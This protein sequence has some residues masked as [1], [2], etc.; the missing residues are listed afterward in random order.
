[1][2][3]ELIRRLIAAGGVVFRTIRAY[4]ARIIQNGSARFR[5]ATSLTRQASKLTP[6]LLKKVTDVGK[7]PTKREDYIETQQLF[8]AK[9]LIILLVVGIV[10]GAMLIYFVIWPWLVRMFFTAKFWYQDPKTETYSGKVILFYDEEKENRMFKGRL[11]EG[12]IQ[13][14]GEAYD[15]NGLLL[16][17]GDYVD[18]LYSGQGELYEAG[19][20]IYKGG[21]EGGR[22]QGQGLAY[23]NGELVYEGNF[24]GGMYSGQGRKFE[25]G[26]VHYEGSFDQGLY[27]GEGS[28]YTSSG[29]LKY[30]GEFSLGLRSGEGTEYL[31]GKRLY[32]GQF[33]DDLYNGEGVL[34]DEEVGVRYRGSFLDGVYS[35]SGVLT[36]NSGAT[37]QAEFEQGNPIGTAS[38]FLDGKL[39]Y[40]GS[41]RQMVPAGTGTLY[42]SSGEAMY[43]GPMEYGVIDGGK[44]LGTSAADLRDML[45][46]SEEQTYDQ[47][48]VIACEALG[49]AAFCSY[50]QEDADAQV[51][52]VYL[53]VPQDNR[54]LASLMWPSTDDFEVLTLDDVVP[55]ERAEG[56]NAAT[57]F[58]IPSPV[59]LG[60]RAWC[61]P[62]LW[63][64]HTLNLW[65]ISEEDPVV[66]AEWRQ[67]EQIP[68]TEPEEEGTITS[69]QRVDALIDQ[70]GIL[71]DRLQEE[72]GAEIPAEDAG[73]PGEDMLGAVDE[74]SVYAVLAAGLSYFEHQQLY[75]VAQ[76]NLEICQ[77]MAEKEKSLVDVGKG[78]PD[79]LAELED[80]AT[81]LDGQIGTYTAQMRKEARTIE[82]ATGGSVSDYDLASLLVYF[83]VSSLD[84]EALQDAAVRK[85]QA[86]AE[87]QAMKEA[88]EE[89]ERKAEEEAIRK[90]TEEAARK[91][92]EEA[93]Q[94]A[95]EE[96]AKKAEEEAA[97]KEEEEG[98]NPDGSSSSAG[99]S[100]G[101]GSDSSAGDTSSAGSDSSAGGSDSS[102][103]DTSEEQK[104]G[105]SQPGAVSEGGSAQEGMIRRGSS[106]QVIAVPEGGYAQPGSGSGVTVPEVVVPEVDKKALLDQLEDMLLD[107]ELSYQKI[108]TAMKNYDNAMTGLEDLEGRNAVGDTTKEEVQTARME[109]NDRRGALYSAIVAF[110][111]QAAALDEFTDGELSGQQ[112]WLSA[113]LAN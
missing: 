63:E 20:L 101:A 68:V 71:S 102:G 27:H 4:F 23:E 1:M 56:G 38:C 44:L 74:E 10:V 39:Y 6:G 48:F 22:F 42:N 54:A 58:L 26:N 78:D 77:S 83:D 36:L 16:Y 76:E 43:T 87:D 84:I 96:A 91:A 61:Q 30:E 41:M 67:G 17:V 107:L 100:S 110:S 28:L 106:S 72:G 32:K 33:E 69:E 45:T 29:E 21:F 34:Y 57:D 59:D 19:S 51:Y 105:S 93:T 3:S 104:P 18:G 24:S 79:R 49:F 112:G 5:N 55:P 99:D 97:K 14:K 103:G 50:A 65:C 7:K 12:A 8:I 82:D 75:T 60:Q 64:D 94:K 62:F 86:A 35:G 90:E 11:R 37:I 15:E 47:G 92:A 9:S 2:L 111:R 53:S 70:L 80:Q 31:H 113:V 25:N 13:G 85:A 52:A 40:E 46:E 88:A 73:L 95:L 108:E 89:A 66:L 109:A 98:K 81:Q